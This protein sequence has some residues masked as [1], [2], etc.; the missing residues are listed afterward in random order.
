MTDSS[1]THVDKR[2]SAHGYDRGRRQQVGEEE[3]G[4]GRKD[5]RD[6]RRRRKRWCAHDVKRP[7]GR[8]IATCESVSRLVSDE[9]GEE[10][11]A[12]TSSVENGVARRWRHEG[13][14]KRSKM[15]NEVVAT[16]ARTIIIV[17][18]YR[19]LNGSCLARRSEARP[20]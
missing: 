2:R 1:C 11:P 18:R 19:W 9:Y 20:I 3:Q 8:A 5:E 14:E 17:W 16:E 4:E 10:A 15:A 12:P 7:R 13:R 6:V